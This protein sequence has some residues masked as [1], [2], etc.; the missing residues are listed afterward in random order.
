MLVTVTGGSRLR[1]LIDGLCGGRS[2]IFVVALEDTALSMVACLNGFDFLFLSH[3]CCLFRLS[4]T[5]QE[6]VA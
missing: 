3:V 6:A 5:H 4:F 2:R 1:S